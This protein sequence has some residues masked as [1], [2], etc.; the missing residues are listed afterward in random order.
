MDFRQ[1]A[2][3]VFGIEQHADGKLNALSTFK[4]VYIITKEEAPFIIVCDDNSFLNS[5]RYVLQNK[6]TFSHTFTSLCRCCIIKYERLS[7]IIDIGEFCKRYGEI[8]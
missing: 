3:Y 8:L 7:T 4:D 5:L 1:I 6:Y 2:E